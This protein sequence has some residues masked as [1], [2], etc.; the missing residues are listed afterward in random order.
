MKLFE[1]FDVSVRSAALGYSILSE[2][3]RHKVT[4]L[5]NQSHNRPGATGFIT[6]ETKT[7]LRL[8]GR[9]ITI[10]AGTPVFISQP[11]YMFSG[12]EIG[13]SRAHGIYVLIG[14]KSPMARYTT[15]YMP[16]SNIA[17]PNNAQSRVTTGA[18]AQLTVGEKLQAAL[19]DKIKII[20]TAPMASQAPDIVATVNNESCQ[21]EIKGRNTPTAPI[22]FF[23]IS[24]RRGRSDVILDD[25]AEAITNGKI[26]SFEQMIDVFRQRNPSVG[27]PGD[28]GVPKSGKLPP[29]FRFKDNSLVFQRVR[30][31][32][33][34]H[35]Q[36]HQD[37]YFAV[38]NRSDMNT[39]EIFWT[40]TGPNPLNAPEFPALAFVVLDTYGGAYKGA[41]RIALKAQLDPSIRGLRM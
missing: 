40:G 10:K 4:P 35:M 21:F 29:E 7:I 32:L 20:S 1:L 2:D 30:S 39:T 11:G 23:D 31:F 27:Y 36:A 25:I 16:I 6:R 5:V 3:A 34:D 41:M 17:N 9:S 37:N 26:H 19:G 38:V 13:S 33:V 18:A 12:A 28:D 15:G 24:A 14:L 22:T 8:D